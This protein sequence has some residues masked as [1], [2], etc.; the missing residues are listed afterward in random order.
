MYL[1][2]FTDKTKYVTPSETDLIS[3][4]WCWAPLETF[5]HLDHAELNVDA[6]SELHTQA[7]K[8][9]YAIIS[10]RC[11]SHYLSLGDTWGD[12][13][14]QGADGGQNS[15]F[16]GVKAPSLFG[17]TVLHCDSAN[18]DPRRHFNILIYCR[19]HTGTL[20]NWN[21]L[22]HNGSLL[23][24][25]HLVSHQNQYKKKIP[26]STYW[27]LPH[28]RVSRFMR[29]SQDLVTVFLGSFP[30]CLTLNYAFATQDFLSG[31]LVS[32]LCRSCG[33]VN[34]FRTVHLFKVTPGIRV[35]ISRE[36]DWKGHSSWLRLIPRSWIVNSVWD[37]GSTAYKILLLRLNHH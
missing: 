33:A 31:K 34:I 5:Q 22:H 7:R 21:L 35:R 20:Y 25:I 16:S 1:A 37:S 29:L 36:T 9:R 30:V 8:T 3:V 24:W 2:G 12:N 13:R 6:R 14:V 23:T 17:K 11:G 18:K 32:V 28:E 19:V 10:Q 27:N 26:H 4:L 15:E